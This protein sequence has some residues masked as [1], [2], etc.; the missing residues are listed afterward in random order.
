[1]NTWK[2]RTVAAAAIMAGLGL[3]IT[4]IATAAPTPTPTPTPAVTASTTVDAAVAKQLTYLREEERLARDVYTAL[5]KLYPDATAFSRIAN[6]EQRHFDSMGL[7][8]SRYGL[9]DPSSGLSAGT[10]ANDTLTKLS[11]QLMT[12]AKVS[13]TEAYKVGVAIEQTD[14]ADLQGILARDSEA[15][16][17]RVFTHLL[18]ASQH[19]LDAFTNAVNDGTDAAF[20]AGTGARLGAR[21]D[22][23]GMGMGDGTGMGTG[24]RMG[25]SDS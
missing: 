8:L 2:T 5:Y 6:A 23:Q 12:Q 16:A 17:Q 10:Y 4:A 22:G 1:M 3:G 18:A 24:S 13:V 11:A 25:H 9:A 14:I 21:G 15:D 7:M 19:H 20:C